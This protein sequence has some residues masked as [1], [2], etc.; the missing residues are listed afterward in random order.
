M[1]L[2]AG[3][4]AELFDVYVKLKLAELKKNANFRKKKIMQDRGVD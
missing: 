1:N 4:F 3:L 2:T